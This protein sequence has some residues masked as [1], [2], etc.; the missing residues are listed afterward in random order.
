MV[1]VLPRSFAKVVN[2]NANVAPILVLQLTCGAERGDEGF[3]MCSRIN[4][5]WLLCTQMGFLQL[6][7]WSELVKKNRY[8]ETNMHCCVSHHD[9]QR[10]TAV[11]H[12][13]CL[14]ALVQCLKC[15]SEQGGS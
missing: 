10:T 1:V 12:M 11:R 5:L 14:H 9:A 3:K 4:R 15:Q 7:F 2:T 13:S 8:K 6:L